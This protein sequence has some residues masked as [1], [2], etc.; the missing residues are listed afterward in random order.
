MCLVLALAFA[1]T[2]IGAP[3]SA[4]QDRTVDEWHTWVVS[5]VR[6]ETPRDAGDVEW[7]QKYLG[8]GKLTAACGWV[9]QD[10][11]RGTRAQIDAILADGVLTYGEDF[12]VVK[13]WRYV[14]SGACSTPTPT[15]TPTPTPTPS[16]TATPTPTPS[17]TPTP[18]STPT[19]SATPT[20]EVTPTPTPSV[21]PSATPRPTSTPSPAVTPTP[22]ATEGVGPTPQYTEAGTPGVRRLPATG[23]PVLWFLALVGGGAVAAGLIGRKGARR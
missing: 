20:P 4:T 18:T 17:A 21:S 1:L 5:A 16:E 10:R 7:P 6:T 2:L 23:G 15:V 11:Y 9:Q 12:H 8:A 22:E 19:P 13:D 3:A 14:Y